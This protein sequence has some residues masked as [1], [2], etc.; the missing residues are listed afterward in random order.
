MFEI[1][2][3]VFVSIF[4]YCILKNDMSTCHEVVEFLLNIL[5]A[6]GCIIVPMVFI[7]KLNDQ[8]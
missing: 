4:I 6:G 7:K 8:D 1:N 5:N 2:T 3:N